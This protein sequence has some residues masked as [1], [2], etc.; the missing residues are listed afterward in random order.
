MRQKLDF[1]TENAYTDKITEEIRQQLIDECEWLITEITDLEKTY[2]ELWLR[3]NR[4]DNLERLMNVLRQQAAY[5]NKGKQS[6]EKF[7][8]DINQE[9]PSKWIA[10]KEYEKGKRYAAGIFAQAV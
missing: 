4:P 7:H 6:L 10:A 2:R 3:S 1:Y 5:I 9:I 8:Y